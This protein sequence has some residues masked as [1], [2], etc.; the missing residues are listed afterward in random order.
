MNPIEALEIFEFLKKRK[1]ERAAGL[2]EYLS[3]KCEELKGRE[4]ERLIELSRGTEGVEERVRAEM[5]R[6][7][8]QLSVKFRVEERQKE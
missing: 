5:Q 7:W 2:L 1:D 3:M 4:L 6:K 8:R